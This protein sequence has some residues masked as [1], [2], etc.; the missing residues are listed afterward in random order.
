MTAAD[1]PTNPEPARPAKRRPGRP[2]A[3]PIEQQRE[4]ILNSARAVFAAHDYYGTSIERVAREAGVARQ[5]V[6]SLFGSKDGLFIAVVDDACARVIESMTTRLASDAPPRELISSRV[7]ALFALIEREPEVAAIIRIAEYGGF[8]PAKQD[9]ANG[10]RRIEDSLASLFATA[11]RGGHA[12]PTP[13]AA[14]ALSLITLSMVE[15]VGFRQ[16]SEPAWDT[17]STIELLTEF[18]FGAIAHLEVQRAALESF[19]TG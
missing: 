15:A 3:A 5:L 2:R 9:V 4:M 6:Y 10:R 13:E 11:W 1:T 17:G 16:P 7:N 14:R 19:G 12:N 8:G 18:I